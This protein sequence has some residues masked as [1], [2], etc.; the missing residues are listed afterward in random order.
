MNYK[1]LPEANDKW[2]EEEEG[3]IT[4]LQTQKP[5]YLSMARDKND[6]IWMVTYDDGV[7][8]FGDGERAGELRVGEG[9]AA[10]R[11]RVRAQ[12]EVHREHRHGGARVRRLMSSVSEL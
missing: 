11:G 12:A 1:I 8:R 9:R 7:W 6:A 10:G 5:Y 2:Y 4:K 3:Y